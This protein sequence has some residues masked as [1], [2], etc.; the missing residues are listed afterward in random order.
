MSGS[1][2]KCGIIQFRNFSLSYFFIG[3]W[4]KT[5]WNNGPWREITVDISHTI[6]TG[7]VWW[8]RTLTQVVD[9][10]RYE[11]DPTEEDSGSMITQVARANF[12]WDRHHV[13]SLFTLPEVQ[14]IVQFWPWL[15]NVIGWMNALLQGRYNLHAVNVIRKFKISIDS[16][17][18]IK[19]CL[20]ASPCLPLLAYLKIDVQA[21]QFLSHRPISQYKLH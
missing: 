11:A 18:S 16:N 9:H 1:C 7:F 5:T 15:L 6:A 20:H 21:D 12:L 17:V 19:S 10:P 13:V 8:K 3:C 14:S 4:K 2:Q